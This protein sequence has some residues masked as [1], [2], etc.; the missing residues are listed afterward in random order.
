MTAALE[1]VGEALDE[2]FETDLLRRAVVGV[3]DA[4]DACEA[5]RLAGNCRFDLPHTKT[6]V[7]PRTLEN[8][9]A[10]SKAGWKLRVKRGDIGI[11]ANI[12]APAEAPRS[13]EDF[14]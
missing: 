3:L 13:V 9:R 12:A 2:C 10:S 11:Q 8:E 4:H 1:V 5:E 14:F 6:A 7:P